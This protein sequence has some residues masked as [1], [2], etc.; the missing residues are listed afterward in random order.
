MNICH[1]N[2]AGGFRG[3]ERQTWLLVKALAGQVNQ[4]VVLRK[5][6]ALVPEMKK[7]PEVRVQEIGKPFFIHAPMLRGFSL[8]HAHEA[9]AAHLAWFIH[10]MD[11]TPYVIT[12]R[13]VKPPKHRFFFSRVYAR[14]AQVVAISS[15]VAQ[16]LE[17]ICPALSL[18]VVFSSFSSLPRDETHVT[19]LRQTY[20][21]KFVVGHV[22]A[23]VNKD[24]GQVHLIRAA[25]R[26]AEKV[27]DIRFLFLGSGCDE[28][29]FRRE[30]SGCAAIE[31]LGFREDVGDYYSLFD[32]FVFPSLDEGLGSAILDA[33]YFRVPV[34]ASRTGG[35]PDVV[36]HGST[37]ILVTPRN[38]QELHDTILELYQDPGLRRRLVD[39][40]RQS[41]ERF[42]ITGAAKSYLAIYGSAVSQA[43]RRDRI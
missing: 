1:I 38:E 29:W 7:I 3:G 42:D 30:A 6:S 14:A 24:K 2:L 17:T 8:V 25:R 9:K 36:S 41:L 15:Q 31:F 39:E 16:V 35:I 21:D 12:R 28:D 19:L 34:I 23:L 18:E 27:P 26:I 11:R 32:L 10:C 33:F 22:G 37:G 13:V 40:A 5:G 4:T 20:K 43:G